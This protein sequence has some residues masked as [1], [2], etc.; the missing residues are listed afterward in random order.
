[1]TT[2]GIDLG[3]TYSCI[4]RL[5][6]NGNPEVI[7]I[8]NE[9][10]ELLPSAVYFESEDNIVVGSNAKLMAETDSDKVVQFIKRELG[11]PNA[12]TYEFFGKEYNPVDI[13]ALI[14]KRLV[15]EVEEQGETVKDVVITCPA[16][17]NHE[18]RYLTKKAGELAGLNVL[19]LIN[20]PT[21]AALSYYARQFQEERNIL[22][23]DLGG[24]TFDV[25][26][27]KMSLETNESGDEVQMVTVL[28]TGGNTQL[29]GKDWDDL[30]FKHILA[31]AADEHGIPIEEIDLE[32]R[33]R[34]RQ[35]TEKTK[36]KLTGV[37]KNII[38]TPINGQKSRITITREDFENL[39]KDKVLETM[40][41]VEVALQDAGNIEIDMV[42]L[43]GGSTYMP[44]ISEAMENRF[45]GKVR[46]EDPDRAVV[47][48]AT[49]YATMLVE[50]NNLTA[51]ADSGE[52]SLD[53][54]IS[55]SYDEA[56]EDNQTATTDSEERITGPEIKIKDQVSR[57][58][59][60]RVLDETLTNFIIDNIIK[61]G[62]E[63]PAKA[64]KQYPT[65]FDNL[66]KVELPIFE[67]VSKEDRIPLEVN[68]A[69][70]TILELTNPADRINYLA[71]LELILPP[72]TKKGTKIEVTFIINSSGLYVKAL[73]TETGEFNEV[74]LKM[75]S[76]IDI[77]KS[78]VNSVTVS[79]E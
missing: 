17:F 42:L 2:Y 24:G 30:L 55:D 18:K 58:F 8:N 67:S 32:T 66:E 34:L 44:M 47:K 73:N 60:P 45:P 26:I 75:K 74:N 54:P 68:E 51:K 10:S 12:L 15:R 61:M 37:E 35:E 29:G 62:E 76:E 33:Q 43:V 3:T 25:T 46:R 23:Y 28:A 9:Q 77:T 59:G 57:T 20:E 38:R 19:D 65:A 71:T 6:R 1:M 21:A 50:E 22:I 53:G 31:V 69:G 39:T 52:N 11:Q 4:A 63:M 79:L 7:R 41:Y 56:A 49:I 72:N 40:Q 5:D 14:L 70:E 64:V 48:G 13:S 36:K 78:P 27:A 16:D